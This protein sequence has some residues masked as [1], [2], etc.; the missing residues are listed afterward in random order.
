MEKNEQ[1]SL[2][3]SSE[4]HIKSQTKSPNAI[5]ELKSKQPLGKTQGCVQGK[6]HLVLAS[7]QPLL[8][9]SVMSCVTVLEVE[10]T[11]EDGTRGRNQGHL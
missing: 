5:G 10:T 2:N 7:L 3:H 6:L 4:V 11:A 1:R 8:S 9:L